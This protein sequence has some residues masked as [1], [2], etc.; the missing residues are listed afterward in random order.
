MRCLQRSPIV[1]M[2]Q[3]DQ[4]G[5]RV[6]VGLGSAYDLHLTRT[7]KRATLV[8][9]KTSPV[10]AD[11]L[12]AG[13]YEAAAGLRP[14]LETDAKRLPGLR[15]LD[16][17][18]MRIEQALAVSRGKTEAQGVLNAFLE[19]LLESGFLEEALRRHGVQGASLATKELSTQR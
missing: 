7:L 12:L 11:E 4:P 16:R 14:Q 5:V 19:A 9:V 2:D 13:G 6:V 8:R 3:I 10:V 17:N 1:R 18:F 15:L